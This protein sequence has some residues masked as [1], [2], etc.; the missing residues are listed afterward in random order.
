[1]TDM[2]KF[3]SV[4][5]VITKMDKVSEGKFLVHETLKL[6]FIPFF[7]TYPITIESNTIDH[8]VMICATV[9]KITTIKMSFVLNPDADFTGVKEIIQINR[10]YPF[11]PS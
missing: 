11:I 5:P 3:V 8:S 4:H 10:F 6:G 1:M 7:F 2:Q 9:M